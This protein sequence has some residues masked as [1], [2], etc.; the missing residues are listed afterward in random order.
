MSEKTEEKLDV[1][2]QLERGEQVV[3]KWHN[4]RFAHCSVHTICDNAD[5]V[6]ESTKS[7][8]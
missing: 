4:V 6:T 3:D 8:T 5:R 7:R 2:S 1:I